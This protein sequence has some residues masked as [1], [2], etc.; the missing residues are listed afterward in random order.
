MDPF[1]INPKIEQA[2]TLPATFYRDPNVFERSKETI[3]EAFW[4]YVADETIIDEPNQYFP[5]T[6]L[7]GVL[8]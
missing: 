1:H 5:F 3:F 7:E 8:V 6:L 4:Q 2:S